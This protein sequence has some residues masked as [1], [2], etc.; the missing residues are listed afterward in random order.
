[1]GNNKKPFLVS[2][3]RPAIQY[4]ITHAGDWILLAVSNEAVGADVEF[5]DKGFQIQRYFR[6]TL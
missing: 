1:L 5:V 6:R 4:N 2:D 3:G